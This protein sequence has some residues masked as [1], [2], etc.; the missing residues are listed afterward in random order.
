MSNLMK[1]YAAAFP[2]VITLEDSMR[3]ALRLKDEIERLQAQVR[4]LET[5]RD[6][7]IRQAVSRD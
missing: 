4:Q 2:S 5:E 7:W 3:Q 1:D 6:Q